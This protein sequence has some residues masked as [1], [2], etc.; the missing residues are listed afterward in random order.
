MEQDVPILTGGPLEAVH[1]QLP[2][3][4]GKFRLT[5]KIPRQDL[6]DEFRGS[7]DQKG[8]ALGY[9]THHVGIFRLQQVH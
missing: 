7:T 8:I 1:L 9:P 4:R 6:G 5:R 3:E 2:F